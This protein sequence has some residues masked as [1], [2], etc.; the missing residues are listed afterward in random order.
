MKRF[1]LLFVLACPFLVSAQLDMNMPLELTGSTQQQ[2]QLMG[3]PADAM[4]TSAL[5]AKQ[6]LGNTH[7]SAVAV[8]N[9]TWVVSLESLSG[10]PSAGTHIVIT[11]PNAVSADSVALMVN[12]AGPYPVMIRP[13]RPLSGTDL[14]DGELLSLVF[15]GSTFQR[16]N[17]I[18]HRRRE[19]PAGL[20]AV[21]DQYCIEPDERTM[22][23][24]YDAAR[25]CT[26][27]GLRL[28]T[29]AEWHS[30]CLLSSGLNLQNMTGNWEYTDDTA[31]E[32]GTVRVTGV[33][34]TQATTWLISNGSQAFRCCYTR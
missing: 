11:A 23:S 18:N 17:G 20:V 24:F 9:E 15:D 6:D 19:C 33:T 14:S 4:P 12:E 10:A 7:R 25:I 2:R 30:A 31:N 13:G 27:A 21:N 16:M 8:G 32:D 29:W 26:E 34:C 3:L 22:E 1:I 5:S 28:C